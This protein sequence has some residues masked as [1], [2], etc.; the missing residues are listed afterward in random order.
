MF[1]SD[2]EQASASTFKSATI[3]TPAATFDIESDNSL[4]EIEIQSVTINTSH[5]RNLLD[6]PSSDDIFG[7]IPNKQQFSTKRTKHE[8]DHVTSNMASNSTLNAP[9][10]HSKS[11]PIKVP[12]SLIPVHS[13]QPSQN[14]SPQKLSSSSPFL[15]T[16]CPKT[17]PLQFDLENDIPEKENERRGEP[18]SPG[19]FPPSSP[20]VLQFDDSDDDLAIVQVMSIKDTTEATNIV[21]NKSNQITELATQVN[22]NILP[23][24]YRNIPKP[25]P[26]PGLS[27][28]WKFLDSSDN[29]DSFEIPNPRS[30]L[31]SK[32][33]PE[34]SAGSSSGLLNNINS[35][36]PTRSTKSMTDA[37]AAKLC[38]QLQKEREKRE[39]ERERDQKKQDQIKKT[40]LLSVNK[41][42][43]MDRK[44]A[45]KELIF[46]CHPDVVSE[47]G[48]WGSTLKSHL[49]ELEVRI[50]DDDFWVSKFDSSYAVCIYHEL[51][52][53]YDKIH[54]IFVPSGKRVEEEPIILILSKAV[55]FAKLIKR[56]DQ[57]EA[58][59]KK[60]RHLHPTKKIIY[61]VQGV[62]E[63]VRKVENKKNQ[64]MAAKVREMVAN[65]SGSLNNT[66]GR[67]NR[68]KNSNSI[69]EEMGHVDMRIFEES[70]VKLQVRFGIRIVQTVGS[71][72]TVN[73]ILDLLQDISTRFYKQSKA[74]AN[75]GSEA[76]GLDVRI[77]S[78]N[79]AREVF[80]SALEQIKF[81]TP[82]VSRVLTDSYVNM[83]NMSVQLEDVGKNGVQEMAELRKGNGQTKIGNSIAQ[84][85]KTVLSSTDPD[86]FLS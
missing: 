65:R 44:V 3:P 59:I 40:Q 70:F 9:L 86:Q 67:R 30:V 10:Q 21:S 52:S 26:K 74:E 28:A 56:E 64:E 66:T 18:T 50:K 8:L 78:G 45:V 62:V 34:R 16:K 33:M 4:E 36:Q 60:I 61:I 81:V 77:K 19:K 63:L 73:W 84:T 80:T 47:D 54:G 35:S 48:D 11:S 69:L 32:T 68:S 20:P 85:I 27:D 43:N 49:S 7:T 46:K 25:K 83:F 58:H 39:K 15:T 37:A 38:K 5:K 22:Q 51:I 82:G 31:R 24:I 6:L 55:D 1:D 41:A 29:E 57:L 72:D 13:Y 17:F 2:D 23:S 42:I 71:L 14:R 53:K 76:N 79:D 75:P 12:P